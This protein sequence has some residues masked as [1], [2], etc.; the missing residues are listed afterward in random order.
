MKYVFDGESVEGRLSG[1]YKAKRSN[2][3][4][5]LTYEVPSLPTH[6]VLL[7]FPLETFPEPSIASKWKATYKQDT[8]LVRVKGLVKSSDE[9]G[10]LAIRSSQVNP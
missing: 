3:D 5:Y 2:L 10:Y 4:Q 8:I 9:Y 7:D 1:F 6:E